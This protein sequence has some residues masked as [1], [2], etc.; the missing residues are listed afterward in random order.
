MH[1]SLTGW[2][3]AVRCGVP[4]ARC[5]AGPGREVSQAGQR[6]R[7]LRG[8][9][10]GQLAGGRVQQGSAAG[11]DLQHRGVGA[12]QH[13]QAETAGDDCRV[14]IGAPGH[15]YRTHQ[16]V[17]GEPDQVGRIH[18]TLDEDEVTRRRRGG[19]ARGEPGQHGVGDLADVIGAGRQVR[20]GQRGQDGGLGRRRLPHRV[21]SR[22]SPR[23]RRHSGFD[24]ARI[25]SDQRADRDDVGLLVAS[26]G[27]QPLR[28]RGSLRRHGRER[29]PDLIRAG[30]PGLPLEAGRID[31]S[32]SGAFRHRKPLIA[33]G[34][35]HG[36]ASTS[37]RA[38]RI[39]TDEAAP[40]SSWPTLRGPR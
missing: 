34:G 17:L 18:L 21:G 13:G 10:G 30:G 11:R 23:D 4:A 40:G 36:A 8:G 19:L 39:S 7:V 12:G 2:P 1:S 14:G 25:E 31:L 15:R 3:S 26:L 33:A 16:P 22:A 32:R 24:Q 20:V 29:L 38:V 6:L 35:R 9:I 27:V 28:Q 37:R 5:G